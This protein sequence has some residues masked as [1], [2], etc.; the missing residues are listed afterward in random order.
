M[1]K[2][3]EYLEEANKRYFSED[4]DD[5]L[6]YLKQEKEHL[7]NIETSFN[8]EQS[9]RVE[10]EMGNRMSDIYPYDQNYEKIIELLKESIEF[11]IKCLKALIIDK[12]EK[13]GFDDD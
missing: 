8:F 5:L 7:K 6:L 12:L 3:K 2:Y 4:L 11:D 1:K 13:G 10:N 9:F